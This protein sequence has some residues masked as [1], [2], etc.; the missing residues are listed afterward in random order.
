MTAFEKLSFI[1]RFEK[2]EL[3]PVFLLE[4]RKEHLRLLTRRWLSTSAEELRAVFMA[5]VELLSWF[6][7]N[8]GLKGGWRSDGRPPGGDHGGV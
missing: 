5:S 2:E 8:L 7:A 1:P 4:F 6:L 3:L